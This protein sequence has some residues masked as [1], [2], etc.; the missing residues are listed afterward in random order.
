MEHDYS[1]LDQLNASLKESGLHPSQV[2]PFMVAERGD[3]FPA[4][5]I[6]KPKPH[7]YRG[8]VKRRPIVRG[9][10]GTL[11]LKLLRKL[12]VIQQWP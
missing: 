11:V 7:F 3:I 5:E 6:P 12:G 8:P 4:I 2:A 10:L 9:P 1:A